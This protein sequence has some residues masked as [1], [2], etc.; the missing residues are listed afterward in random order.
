MLNW[1]DRPFLRLRRFVDFEITVY[2]RYYNVDKKVRIKEFK[3]SIFL[4]VLS[5]DAKDR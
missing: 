3:N 5:T 4:E 2:L 1:R